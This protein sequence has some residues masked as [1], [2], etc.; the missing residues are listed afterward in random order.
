MA[1]LRSQHRSVYRMTT[2]HIKI[3]QVPILTA[4]VREAGPRIAYLG[5]GRV[6]SLSE[7]TSPATG[8]VS[9]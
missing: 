7:R 9:V 4:D 2:Q 3:G 8:S 5:N 6:G 1:C